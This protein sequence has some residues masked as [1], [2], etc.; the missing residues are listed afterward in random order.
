MT[1][2]ITCCR[3]GMD[4]LGWDA[5]QGRGQSVPYAIHQSLCTENQ[6]CYGCQKNV[7]W[8]KI[9]CT[10]SNTLYHLRCFVSVSSDVLL[11]VSSFTS[12]FRQSPLFQETIMTCL[13]ALLVIIPAGMWNPLAPARLSVSQELLAATAGSLLFCVGGR[14]E[15]WQ[16][17]G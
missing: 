16:E 8:F 7:L 9:R 2:R 15:R 13:P 10:S 12:Q 3:A 17:V 11:P 6:E 4:Q 5:Q 14:L 1:E